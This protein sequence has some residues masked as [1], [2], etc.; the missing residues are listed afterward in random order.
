MKK[1]LLLLVITVFG[2]SCISEDFESMKL[3]LDNLDPFIEKTAPVKD[4]FTTI[5]KADDE[6]ICETNET[7][8]YLLP[9][10]SVETIEYSP[11]KKDVMFG[12]WSIHKFTACFEDTRGGDND[13]NDFICYI[14]IETKKDNKKDS[15]YVDIY[16]QPIA[17]GAGTLLQFGIKLP[18]GQNQIISNNILQDFFPGITPK[19][20]V[21]TVK[22]DPT[23]QT[24]TINHIKKFSFS[25]E[26]KSSVP[27]FN[28]FIINE[29]GETLYLALNFTDN[30]NVI[31]YTEIVGITG[32]PLGIATKN[33]FDYP[34]EKINI[35][36]CYSGFN[37]WVTGISTQIGSRTGTTNNIFIISNQG[38]GSSGLII[39]S[40]PKNL[41]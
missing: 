21:N 26:D 13:Y 14:T 39:N 17:Y 38:N 7:F 27:K 34:V 35:S 4:G 40:N 15:L 23:Y 33:K 1:L 9:K 41:F 25:Q 18:N 16:I 12:S 10:G 29:S 22:T 32:Y 30:G 6:I 20:Y 11:M 19:S 24:N 31:D 28:P 5:I 36:A 3:D 8:N 37:S 2:T